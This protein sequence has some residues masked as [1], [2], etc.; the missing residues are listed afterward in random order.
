MQDF[1]KKKE[2]GFIVAG[3]NSS[4]G[5]TIVMCLLMSALQKRNIS[6]QPFK[7]GPDYI[8]PGFHSHFSKK[9][10]V[11]LDPWIMGRDHI[12]E[13]VEEFTQN[14]FGIVEGV[15]GLFDGSDPHSDEGSTMEVARW[16]HWPILLVVSCKNS[17]RSITAAIEGF[18]SE[19]GGNANFLGVILNQLNSESHCEYIKKACSTLKIPI[20]GVLPEIPDLVWPERYLGLQPRIE[21]KLPDVSKLAQTAEKYLKIDILIDKFK[22]LSNSAEAENII[23]HSPS[24]YNKR[25]AVAIDEVFHFYYRAN[26]EWLQKQGVEIIPFSPLRDSKVPE[27]ISAMI[28]GGGFPEIFAQK[29]SV[30]KPML[31]SLRKTVESGI[32]T[33]AECGGLMILAESINL[34]SGEILPMAGLVPGIFKMTNQLQHFGY[35]KVYL[36]NK[37]ELRGHEFHYSKWSAE[38]S[39]A[40]L[41]EVTR[42]S[43]GIS[44]MEGFRSANLHASYVHLYF[45]QA[46]SLIGEVL[47]IY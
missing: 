45:P 20:L 21:Q 35:C 46:S 1:I 42:H 10:S 32:P 38:E 26:M 4:N 43:T 7:V 22:S 12:V 30:N 44:R 14:T 33:Y 41:W 15:M 19:G 2:Q 17:G 16:L 39:S 8:D 9:S 47:K 11:N 3:M 29:I 34:K 40:N 24:N 28:L 37:G 6:V 23:F 25:I 36:P 5:K 27:N 31:S 13:A 18:I